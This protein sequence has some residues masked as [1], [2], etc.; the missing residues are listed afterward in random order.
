MYGS[1]VTYCTDTFVVTDFQVV[2]RDGPRHDVKAICKAPAKPLFNKP[3]RRD[4]RARCSPLTSH[5]KPDSLR[6]R[7]LFQSLV[8]VCRL[9][10]QR[11]HWDSTNLTHAL[12]SPTQC[13]IAGPSLI[14]LNECQILVCSPCHGNSSLILL[15]YTVSSHQTQLNSR[16][17]CCHSQVYFYM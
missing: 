1:H 9:P 16:E 2:L 3:C 17:P 15:S 10:P 7:Q 13:F 6:P 5:V 12:P 8:S 11:S 4:S 14:L